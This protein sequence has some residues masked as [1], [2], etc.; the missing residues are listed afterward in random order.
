MNKGNVS[1][2]LSIIASLV[3]IDNQFDKI[4]ITREVE[5]KGAVRLELYRG[6]GKKSL[7]KTFIVNLVRNARMALIG[8]KSRVPRIEGKGIA[9]WTGQLTTQPKHVVEAADM[10]IVLVGLGITEI[11]VIPYNGKFVV[12][13]VVRPKRKK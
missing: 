9:N 2:L 5:I 3:S 6:K 4:V 11:R 13:K 8:A 10:N 12:G 7:R 1:E